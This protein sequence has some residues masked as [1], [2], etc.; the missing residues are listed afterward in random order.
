MP[1]LD[2]YRTPENIPDGTHR[3]WVLFGKKIGEL[4]E[5]Q[6]FL[7]ADPQPSGGLLIAVDPRS[8]T[9]FEQV[10]FEYKLHLKAFGQLIEK[11]E[12][13]IYVR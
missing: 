5:E 1:I 7:L 9:L 12:K 8:A 6:R 2:E 13:V 4:T 10:A 11:S 3:N